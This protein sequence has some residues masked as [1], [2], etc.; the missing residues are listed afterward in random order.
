MEKWRWYYT[1]EWLYIIIEYATSL[2][3]YITGKKADT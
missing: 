3:I 2:Y 1:V